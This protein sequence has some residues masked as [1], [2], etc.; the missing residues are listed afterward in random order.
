M[1]ETIFRILAAVI[2][3]TCIG[4]SSY[5]R[6]KADKDSGEKVSRAVDGKV[7][8][9]FIRV[10]GLILWLS[11]LVYLVNPDWMAWSKMGL[12]EWVRWL[13]MVIGV[14]GAVLIYWLFSSIRSGITA[15][16]ATRKEHTL[17]TSGPYRWIRHP[18]Y[19][20]GTALF[21]AF[22]MMA[23]NWFIAGMGILTFIMM[24]IRTPKEEANLIEKFGDEYREYMK[25]T[26]A[27]LPKLF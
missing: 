20:A 5:Y 11:P 6:R 3:F 8:M 1:N 10:G 17:V 7:M 12:P 16:S 4:I 13:G 22:G 19:T 27:F 15:T 2:L 9:T 23:D 21:I 14:L 24:A 26:G 18:L 25:H